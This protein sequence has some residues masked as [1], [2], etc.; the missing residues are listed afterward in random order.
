[1][2]DAETS[3][4]GRVGSPDMTTREHGPRASRLKPMKV[5]PTKELIEVRKRF[6]SAVLAAM[7]GALN[8]EEY[9][10]LEALSEH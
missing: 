8:A 5:R 6:G 4:G 3:R 9:L 2:D 7:L 10:K 1:M